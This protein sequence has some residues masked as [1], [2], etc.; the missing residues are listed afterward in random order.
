MTRR[1]SPEIANMIVEI[2][3]LQLQRAVRDSA[4]ARAACDLAIEHF[5]GA[6]AARDAHVDAWRQAA[7]EGGLSIPVLD[8]FAHAFSGIASELATAREA[9][10]RQERSFEASKHALVRFDRLAARARDDATRAHRRHRQMLE[11]RRM[12]ERETQ[13]APST[14]DR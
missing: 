7:D 8:N 14:E 1:S 9:M 5:N 6:V 2:R 10:H 4:R 11:E 13:P 12:S 3:K